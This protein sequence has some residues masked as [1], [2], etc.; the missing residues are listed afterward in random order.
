[1]FL[2]WKEVLLVLSIIFLFTCSYSDRAR[3][4]FPLPSICNF[5]RDLLINHSDFVLYEL[6]ILGNIDRHIYIYMIF[7]IASIAV[8]RI[9]RKIE[10]VKQEI[11]I[12]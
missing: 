6:N 7:S 10:T 3:L 8:E 9:R 5:E 11:P 2:P 4:S 12:N 1:M